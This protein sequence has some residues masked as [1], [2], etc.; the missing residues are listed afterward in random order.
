AADVM[1]AALGAA[2][3]AE[4]FRRG[5]TTLARSAARGS[6]SPGTARRDGD[7]MRLADLVVHGH[8]LG[9]RAASVTEPTIRCSM[10]SS[11]VPAD[12]PKEAVAMKRHADIE[13]SIRPP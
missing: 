9:R 6:R 1:V 5:W 3:A 12:D 8:D 13:H 7:S 11:A 4:T 10:P 2:R